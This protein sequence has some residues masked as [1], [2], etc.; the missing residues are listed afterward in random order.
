MRKERDILRDV[1]HTAIVRRQIDPASAIVEDPRTNDHSAVRR[2][3]ETGDGIEHGGLA[4][5]GRAK[6]RRDAPGQPFVNLEH[7]VALLEAEVEL[8]HVRS[9]AR[10]ERWLESHNAQKAITAET[11][12]SVAAS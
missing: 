8:D 12:S 3:A 5:T 10:A 7:E 1:A 11:P 4:R 6:Q 9:P 2:T